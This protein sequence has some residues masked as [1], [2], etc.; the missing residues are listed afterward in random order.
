MSVWL[1]DHDTKY[2]YWT[3]RELWS[4]QKNILIMPASHLKTIISWHSRSQQQTITT[5]VWSFL[6]YLHVYLFISDLNL[7]SDFYMR[8]LHDLLDRIQSC[9][10]WVTGERRR[11]CQ[12]P[13]QWSLAI[14]AHESLQWSAGDIGDW[15]TSDTISRQTPGEWRETVKWR[16]WYDRNMETRLTRGRSQDSGMFC[17]LQTKDSWY[18]E[19]GLCDFHKPVMVHLEICDSKVCRVLALFFWNG[20]SGDF[21]SS[22]PANDF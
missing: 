11:G 19:G 2:W 6:K 22:V 7:C 10:Q 12:L 21:L 20:L 18:P 9:N 8:N 13:K 16:Q 14:P 15:V 5:E 1:P 3:K 4:T 17:I